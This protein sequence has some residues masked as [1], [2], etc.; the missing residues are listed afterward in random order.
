MPADNTVFWVKFS[1]FLAE[2]TSR[3]FK[4]LDKLAPNP[5]HMED[6]PADE[7]LPFI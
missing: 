1:L 3:E 2:T 7:Y 6:T 4:L 5:P